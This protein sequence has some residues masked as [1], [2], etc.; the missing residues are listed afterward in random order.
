M[1]EALTPVLPEAYARERDEPNMSWPF[2]EVWVSVVCLSLLPS[3]PLLVACFV[4]VGQSCIA[5]FSTQFH[6]ILSRCW[7]TV[8]SLREYG[9]FLN[10]IYFCKCVRACVLSQFFPPSTVWGWGMYKVIRLVASD[11][12]HW[13]VLLALYFFFLKIYFNKKNTLYTLTVIGFV[14]VCAHAC[15]YVH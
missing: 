9:S 8:I 2:R 11:F 4:N 10:Y 15:V 13:T 6:V 3:F 1:R 12:T 7:L 5:M 14:C